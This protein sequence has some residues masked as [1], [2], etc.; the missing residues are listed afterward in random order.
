MVEC[1]WMKETVE[2]KGEAGCVTSPRVSVQRGGRVAD[3]AQPPGEAHAAPAGGGG[4]RRHAES[5]GV[6]PAGQ[7][8]VAQPAEPGRAGPRHRRRAVPLRPGGWGTAP[9]VVV[10]L[11]SRVWFVVQKLIAMSAM[12]KIKI[13][14]S[15]I[16]CKWHII[17]RLVNPAISFRTTCLLK[18]PI[19]SVTFPNPAVGGR[20]SVNT[21]GNPRQ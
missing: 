17:L 15:Y 4:V 12:I 8:A 1:A 13:S 9:A 19:W 10:T 3:G 18:A 20:A 14:I 5:G 2:M 21:L 7:A 6:R 11:C 16:G